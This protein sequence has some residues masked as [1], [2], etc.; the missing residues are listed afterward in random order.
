MRVPALSCLSAHCRVY[1]ADL[2]SCATG[3]AGGLVSPPHNW[4]VDR[5]GPSPCQL[6]RWI[7]II[8][9]PHVI[10]GLQVL[11]VGSAQKRTTE[12]CGAD[13][14]PTF[15]RGN[16]PFAAI[17]LI[18]SVFLSKSTGAG[19]Y[20]YIDAADCD[21]GPNSCGSWV[22]PDTACTME[23][24]RYQSFALLS[25]SLHRACRSEACSERLPEVALTIVWSHAL[26]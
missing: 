16:C 8:L 25:R 24:R 20:C 3:L 17:V 7:I 15:V 10:R 21:A 9:P 11:H 22:S 18:L 14:C 12:W 4:C 1:V 23:V 2:A 19:H 6:S 26:V 5:I 13:S